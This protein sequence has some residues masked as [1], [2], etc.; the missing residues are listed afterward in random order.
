MRGIILLGLLWGLCV[1]AIRLLSQPV[2]SESRANYEMLLQASDA[3]S[4]GGQLYHQLRQVKSL[5]FSSQPELT[6]LPSE[7]GYFI[8]VGELDLGNTSITTLPPEI[9]Q[10]TNLRWLNLSSPTL[11]RLPTEI[12]QLTQLEQLYLINTALTI[13]PPEIAQL[14]HLQVLDVSDSQISELP[15][16]LEDNP[17]LT[18]YFNG[19]P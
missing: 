15:A 18:I 11:M 13:L 19:P 6:E 16:G 17:N 10:L 2:T 3:S 9:G 7:I 12:G 5:R 4:E 8:N 1:L 14:P